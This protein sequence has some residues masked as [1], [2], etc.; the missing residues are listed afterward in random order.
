MSTLPTV[1]LVL[2][3]LYLT[4]YYYVSHAYIVV[5]YVL[6]VGFFSELFL[7]SYEEFR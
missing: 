3:H 4:V 5:Y 2:R 6:I 7:V 1:H